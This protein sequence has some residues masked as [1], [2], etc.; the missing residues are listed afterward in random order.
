MASGLLVRV[1]GHAM[2]TG[3]GFHIIWSRNR[4][5]SDNAARCA[6]G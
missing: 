6:A 4:E 2:R 3:K 5:L 1:T